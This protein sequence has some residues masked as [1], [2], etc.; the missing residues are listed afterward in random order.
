MLMLPPHK[1]VDFCA[2]KP[3]MSRVRVPINRFGLETSPGDQLD[4]R[5]WSPGNEYVKSLVLKNVSNSTIKFRYKQTASKAFS[6]DFP[7]LIKL[8][9]GMSQALKVRG[10]RACTP[11]P[12]SHTHKQQ[13]QLQLQQYQ[14]GVQQ[15]QRHACMHALVCGC[16]QCDLWSQC[17]QAHVQ[18]HH[19][20]WSRQPDAPNECPACYSCHHMPA[21]AATLSRMAMHLCIPPAHI[22]LNAHSQHAHA[23]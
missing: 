9:P 1:R 5:Q 18:L 6:M 22:S 10:R 12:P 11:L 16:V 2:C 23:C 21:G 13:E 3:C 17:T 20:Q 8:R 4:F 14:R 7:E 15:Q 19:R